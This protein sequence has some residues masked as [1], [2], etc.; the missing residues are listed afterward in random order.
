MSPWP[1]GNLYKCFTLELLHS[2]N[3]AVTKRFAEKQCMFYMHL[4]RLVLSRL[5][6]GFQNQRLSA[7]PDISRDITFILNNSSVRSAAPAG[8]AKTQ[9]PMMHW[10]KT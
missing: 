1:N 3:V 4:T 10:E 2:I 5:K 8:D 7:G 9:I 6:S